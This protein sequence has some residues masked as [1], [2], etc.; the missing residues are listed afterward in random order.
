[1]LGASFIDSLRAGGYFD[2]NAKVGILLA[3]IGGGVN[4]HLADLWKSRLTAL[5]IPVASTFTYTFPTGYSQFGDLASQMNSAA[6]QFKTAGVD[7][8]L[9]TPDNGLGGTFFTK[10][11][12]PQGYHPRFG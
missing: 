8:V 7:H 9:T 2:Q 4:Q 6:L 12:D 10:A 1:R 5:G 11:A 3:D